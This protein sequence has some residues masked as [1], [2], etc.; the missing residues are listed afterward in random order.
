VTLAKV[1]PRISSELD[2]KSLH[3]SYGDLPIDEDDLVTRLFENGK[4]DIEI[5]RDGN[6]ALELMLTAVEHAQ[7]W[8]SYLCDPQES[9]VA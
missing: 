2:L 4:R 7:Q 5:Q 6:V 9:L 8:S 3:D 1:Y